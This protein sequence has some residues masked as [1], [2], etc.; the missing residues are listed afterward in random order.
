MRYAEDTKYS[1]DWSSSFPKGDSGVYMRKATHMKG[2]SR[3]H[4][5]SIKDVEAQRIDIFP[6]H[7]G[8]SSITEEINNGVELTELKV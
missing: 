8:A 2:K 7:W 4:V 3:A 1:D 5:L 6:V